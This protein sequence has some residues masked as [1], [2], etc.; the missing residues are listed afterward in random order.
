MNRLQAVFKVCPEGGLTL[1]E[2]ADGV[3][4]P[5]IIVSTGCNFEVSPDLKPMQQVDLVL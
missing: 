1:I 5:E 4:L 2:I 3:E